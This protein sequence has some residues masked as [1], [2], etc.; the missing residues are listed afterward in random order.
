ML[1]TLSIDPGVA[2]AGC[3]CALFT[4]TT[5]VDAWFERVVRFRKDVPA[6]ASPVKCGAGVNQVVVERPVFQGARSLN[7]RPQDLMALAWEGALL[8]GAFAGR[9]ACPI[10]EL[11]PS[12]VTDKRCPLHGKG[13]APGCAVACTCER[14]WKG[15]EQKPIHHGRL[16]RVLTPSERTVLGGRA[17][18]KH[19]EAAKEKG[20][21]DRWSRPGVSYYPRA[22]TTHNLLDATAMGKYFL[23]ELERKG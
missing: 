19:I 12:D 11:P 5:L 13:P 21:L 7:A 3:A 18:E 17:T 16:W 4:G 9:D 14:G 10:Y 2:G 23:G 6:S 20:A 1:T 15:S 8:A 22:F